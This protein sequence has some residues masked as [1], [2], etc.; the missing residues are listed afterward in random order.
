MP[1]FIPGGMI[2]TAA[3]AAHVG[4]RQSSGRAR[5][6]RRRGR[7]RAGAARAKRRGSRR[8]TARR[9][10]RGGSRK[11]KPGTKAWMAYIRSK[12]KRK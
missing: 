8:S 3:H 4:A 7:A 9:A 6:R 10:A 2:A 12:R 11:P 5:K 1:G